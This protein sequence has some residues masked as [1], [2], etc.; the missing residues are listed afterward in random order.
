MVFQVEGVETKNK[1]KFTVARLFF[2]MSQLGS[3]G[4]KRNRPAFTLAAAALK[5]V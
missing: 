3:Q 1:K 2:R 4:L 5:Q